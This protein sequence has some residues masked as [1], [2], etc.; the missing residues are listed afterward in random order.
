M[1]NEPGDPVHACRTQRLTKVT[2]TSCTYYTIDDFSGE[3]VPAMLENFGVHIEAGFNLCAKGL[4][5]HAEARFAAGD[6]H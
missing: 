5:R 6:N 2:D 4:K 1:K 3:F